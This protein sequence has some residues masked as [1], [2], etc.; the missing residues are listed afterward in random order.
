[1][2][3]E[4][5]NIFLH[6][7]LWNLFPEC[8]SPWNLISGDPLRANNFT[9]WGTKLFYEGSLRSNSQHTRNMFW[10]T[11]NNSL[12]S[13]RSPSTTHTQRKKGTKTV[14]LGYYRFKWYPFFKGA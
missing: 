6:P 12:M 2:D 10:S 1:M 7:H 11:G 3:G 9:K 14:P 13:T 8:P 5:R 4:V